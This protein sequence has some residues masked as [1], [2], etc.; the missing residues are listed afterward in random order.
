M[1]WTR[2]PASLHP[3]P[4]QRRQNGIWRAAP[5]PQLPDWLLLHLAQGITHIG[6]MASQEEG[7][8]RNKEFKEVGKIRKRGKMK[9]AYALPCSFKDL[10]YLLPSLEPLSPM[11]SA[12]HL[13]LWRKGGCG[14]AQSGSETR[15]TCLS[16]TEWQPA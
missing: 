4:P 5:W 16:V 13:T 12:L 6:C 2:A 8:E 1:S 14:K 3:S 7:K 11:G 15:Q 10:G 9:D